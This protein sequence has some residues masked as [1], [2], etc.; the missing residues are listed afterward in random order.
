V[1]IV[2]DNATNRHIAR[3]YAESWGMV[4][5]DTGSPVESLEWIRRG[6]PFDVAIVDMQ[7]PELD[8]LA[9]AREIRQQRDAERLPLILLTSLGR[10]EAEA[11]RQF[12]ASLTK[13]IRPSQL[14]DVLLDVL[15]ED[16]PIAP[17]EREVEAER[18]GAAP[19]RAPLRVLVAEDNAVNQRLALLLLEKQGHRA[20][21]VGNGAEA[22]EALERG[23]YDVVLM[24]V[25]MPEM[26]GL[27]ATRRIH[28]RWASERPR[29]IAVTA[30]AMSEE[31]DRCLAAGM[32]DYLSKPIR[33]EELTA[34]LDD[35]ARRSQ[36]A[37]NTSAL[38]R[39]AKTLG[40]GPAVAELIDTFFAE[41]PKLVATLQ[42]AARAG[43]AGELRRAA[44]TL[45][46]NAATFGAERL[47]ELCRRLEAMGEAETL[48]EAEQ[49]AERAENEY[50]HVH[51]A[52]EGLRASGRMT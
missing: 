27:E 25:Q 11:E 8:G 7:M 24:D 52:L 10:R 16:A 30:G 14:Y 43:D 47:A 2:D 18:A 41:A 15:G 9:L 31:R 37:L 23:R 40:E 38:E 33:V 13:P 50:A 28:E 36:D 12:A 5:R 4:A 6:D 45:K 44:H 22:L 20:D 32:D 29:I 3:A 34:A 21:V 1:L 49:L 26:D 46:A 19:V 35:V 17:R 51:S 48:S 42:E 39:L